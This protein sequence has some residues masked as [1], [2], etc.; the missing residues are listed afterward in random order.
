MRKIWPKMNSS[1]TTATATEK[2]SPPT[3]VTNVITSCICVL[4]VNAGNICIFAAREY[5][6]ETRIDSA[7]RRGL[8][9]VLGSTVCAR[10]RGGCLL[11]LRARVFSK[12][13]PPRAYAL[14]YLNVAPSGLGMDGH[15][16]R[17]F[18]SAGAAA[19]LCRTRVSL[20]LRSGEAEPY[21]QC[22]SRARAPAP[23]KNFLRRVA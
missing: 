4:P 6:F 18:P 13:W 7:I 2:M 15:P 23:H 3:T 1:T 11:A 8:S 17:P 22:S 20:R 16:G 9:C 5:V 14:G 19:W 10:E 21:G 12:P